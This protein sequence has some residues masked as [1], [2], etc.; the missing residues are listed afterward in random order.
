MKCYKFCLCLKGWCF[1]GGGCL[2][3]DQIVIVFFGGCIYSRSLCCKMEFTNGA[4][5]GLA[6]GGGMIKII[7]CLKFMNVRVCRIDYCVFVRCDLSFE[8]LYIFTFVQCLGLERNPTF[9]LCGED[10]FIEDN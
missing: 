6:H 8:I 2:F 9:G 1:H 7:G 4:T 5:W 10:W 3:C